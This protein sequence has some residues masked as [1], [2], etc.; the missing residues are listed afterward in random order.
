[1]K[2]IKICGLR[3]SEDIEYVNQC[4][5]DYIG[6]I[7]AN[8][9]RNVTEEQARHLKKR[10]SPGISAVG[11]F[12]NEKNETIIRLVKQ[13]II[14]AIQLHGDETEETICLLKRKTDVPVIKAVRVRETEDILAADRLS[15]DFL[16]LDTY[17]K[18][19]YGGTGEAFSW[20]KIP[21]NICHPFFLAGGLTLENLSKALSVPA[22]GYDISGGVETAGVKDFEKIKQIMKLFSEWRN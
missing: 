19:V 14:D 6:F 4:L 16:L 8:T 7:F 21:N 2:K 17:R 20:D 3:R 12:V 15:C 11:V 22:Y 1:M 18:G 9:R 13:G 5:P 10:L